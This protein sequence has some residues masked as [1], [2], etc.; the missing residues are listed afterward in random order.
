MSNLF[1]VLFFSD[2][3]CL[4]RQLKKHK[5]TC[6]LSFNNT[7]TVDDQFGGSDFTLTVLRSDEST[8]SVEDI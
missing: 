7:E 2:A 4:L 8:H 6:V 3:V 1:Y 5:T